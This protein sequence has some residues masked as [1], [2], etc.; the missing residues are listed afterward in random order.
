MWWLIVLGVFLVI[1]NAI[2][3]FLLAAYNFAQSI[4]AYSGPSLSPFWF[5]IPLAGSVLVICSGISLFKNGKRAWIL[6]MISLVIATICSIGVY[7]FLSIEIYDSYL[8][9]IIVILA[10]LIIYVTPLILTILSRK[11]YF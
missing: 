2:L 11:D 4:D 9:P 7:L 3:I 10:G 1:C 6:S 5:L 8:I